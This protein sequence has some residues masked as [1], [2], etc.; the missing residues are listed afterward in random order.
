MVEIN[1]DTAR[2]LGIESGDMVIVETP[3]GQAQ[4]KAA[5]TTDIHPKVVSVPHGWGGLA[6]QNL[7]TNDDVHDP[8]WGGLAM[9]A[10]ACRVRKAHIY[11]APSFTIVK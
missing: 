3:K 2:S 8:I 6:N 9:R 4:M 11:Q 1:S 10:L 5:V 7:L